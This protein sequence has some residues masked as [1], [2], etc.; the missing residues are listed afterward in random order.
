MFD[1]PPNHKY[2]FPNRGTFDI[3]TYNIKMLWCAC[4]KYCIWGLKRSSQFWHHHYLQIIF[5]STRVTFNWTLQKFIL[6]STKLNQS[7]LNELCVCIKDTLVSDIIFCHH[8]YH[9]TQV[10]LESD[11]CVRVSLTNCTLLQ[12]MQVR[13]ALVPQIRSFFEHCSKRGGGSN[14]CSKILEQILYD[15]KG[16]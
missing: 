3:D 5:V 8:S 16:I 4:F 1:L 13:G 14:P 9:W 15:F 12:V 6:G 2:F 11:L 7:S 10:Y